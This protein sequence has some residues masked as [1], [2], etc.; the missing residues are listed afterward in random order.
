M[1]K[2]KKFMRENKFYL[3]VLILG[4][5]GMIYGMISLYDM[6][7]EHSCIFA[8]TMSGIIVAPI[9]V[10][11]CEQK[12][13]NEFS[14]ND[15]IY[16]ALMQVVLMSGLF[17]IFISISYRIISIEYINKFWGLIIVISVVL[18]EFVVWKGSRFYIKKKKSTD[19]FD[20]KYH[21]FFIYIIAGWF[22]T[23]SF[24]AFLISS[25][26]DGLDTDTGIVL[27][28][29]NVFCFYDLALCEYQKIKRSKYFLAY[30]SRRKKCRRLK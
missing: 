25:F 9:Y 30:K 12:R 5:I 26:T 29:G 8:I 7:K 15:M 6:F 23:I 24:V 27:S 19:L 21:M 18:S 3:L 20:E 14:K 4:F 22:T 17:G 10:G 13:K 1:F 2:I 28:I 11:S 16:Y